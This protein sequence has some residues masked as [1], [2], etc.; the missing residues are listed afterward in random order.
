VADDDALQKAFEA[1]YASQ[2][3][4]N[5]AVSADSGNTSGTP[6]QAV[7]DAR[8]DVNEKED[9][10]QTAADTWSNTQLSTVKVQ[11]QT[12]GGSKA[13]ADA[14]IANQ[15]KTVAASIALLDGLRKTK[16]EDTNMMPTIVGAEA[17]KTDDGKDLVP[18]KCSTDIA[19]ADAALPNPIF[20]ATSSGSGSA[21]TDANPWTSIVISYSAETFAK[22]QSEQSWGMSVSGGLNLGLFSLGGA[23]SYE[24]SSGSMYQDMAKC[25]VAISFEAMVVNIQRPWLYGELFSDSELDVPDNIKLSPGPAQMQEW[26]KDVANPDT[27]TKIAQCSMFPAYP[28]ACVVA[29]NTVI[30]FTGQTSHIETHFSQHSNLGSMSVGYGPFTM[31]GRYV[32]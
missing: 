16:S 13:D 28:T 30:E 20:T 3:A 2:G 26:L 15:L 11:L 10:L 31:S 23:Y 1:L 9:A 7:L 4:L 6:S 27:I 32:V 29:A 25:D 12:L 19:P 8:K 22:T 24:E 14:W 18:E 5:V 21:S 17:G